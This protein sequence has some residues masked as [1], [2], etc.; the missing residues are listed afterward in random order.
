MDAWF[1]EDEEVSVHPRDPYTRVD[2]LAPSPTTSRCPYK[3][4]ASY[5]SVEVGGQTFPDLAWTYRTPLPEVVKVAGLICFYNERVGS[6][7]RRGGPGL[8]PHQVQLTGNT[9]LR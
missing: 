8:A 7:G 2:I 4:T 3:G 9:S 1:E 5:W 6:G